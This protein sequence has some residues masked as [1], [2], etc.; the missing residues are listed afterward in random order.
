MFGKVQ[1]LLHVLKNKS[2]DSN[3]LFVESLSINDTLTRSNEMKQAKLKIYLKSNHFDY[4]SLVIGVCATL[5]MI[6]FNLTV[7]TKYYSNLKL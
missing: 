3:F 1:A 5:I 7:R 6:C 4:V 2:N